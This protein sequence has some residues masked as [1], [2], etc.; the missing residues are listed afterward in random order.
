M[1]REALGGSEK[2]N[3]VLR[4]VHG[5]DGADTQALDAGLVQ[6]HPEQVF[7]FNA[8]GEI[9]AVSAEIDPAQH[10]FSITRVTE[11]LQFAN[12]GPGRQAAAFSANKWNHAK[13]AA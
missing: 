7:E 12:H 13:R 10:D 9:A 8:R 1:L 4:D 3:E 2:F 6:N 5:L 11:F